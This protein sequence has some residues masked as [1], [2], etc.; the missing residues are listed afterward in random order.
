MAVLDFGCGMGFFAIAMA[1]LVGD[2]GRVIA[3]D[4]QQKMLDVLN[5]RARKAGVDGRIGT[6]CCQADSLGVTG[7]VDFALAFYSAHEVPEL[8]RL[9]GEIYECLRQDGQFLI[10]EPVGH[11]GAEQFDA[12]ISLSRDVGF[13]VADQPSI[14][15]SRAV[16]L[17]RKSGPGS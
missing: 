17:A 12:L 16:L 13:T 4:L 9:F 1:R 7:P 10:V 14:R 5:K 2:N 6:H 3:V 11:V 15:L 8:R